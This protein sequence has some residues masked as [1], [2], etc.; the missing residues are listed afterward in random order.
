MTKDQAH[1]EY[2]AHQSGRRNSG[3]SPDGSQQGSAAQLTVYYDDSCPMCHAEIC[4]YQRRPGSEFVNWTDVSAVPDGGEVAPGFTKR[5]AMARFH[6][7]QPDGTLISGAAAFAA[8]W[9][10][11]PSFRLVGRIAALPGIVHIL[12]LAYRAMLPIRPWLQ[13]RLIARMQRAS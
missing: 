13:R 11:L 7:R 10:E 9:T 1:E 4:F 6:V 3:G 2:P 12:E 8:L 5:E